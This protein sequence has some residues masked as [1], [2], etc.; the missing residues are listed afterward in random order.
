MNHQDTLLAIRKLLHQE[1]W[2]LKLLTDINGLILTCE[3]LDHEYPKQPLDANASEAFVPLSDELRESL[4]GALAEDEG[5]Q[6]VVV[7]GNILGGFVFIGPFADHDS[8]LAYAESKRWD[9]WD[10][11]PLTPAE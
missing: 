2:D 8:A 4:E 7:T 3:T 10:I 1:A 6:F 11:I 9:Y 5:V